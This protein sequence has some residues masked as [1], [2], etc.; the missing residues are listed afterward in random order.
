MNFGSSRAQRSGN[1]ANERC[2]LIA[3]PLLPRVADAGIFPYQRHKIAAERLARRFFVRVT[4]LFLAAVAET[5]VVVGESNIVEVDPVDAVVKSNLSERRSLKLAV[6]DPTDRATVFPRPRRFV[7]DASSSSSDQEIP[8]T[9]RRVKT[10]H[11]RVNLDSVLLPA[12]TA[13]SI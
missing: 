3:T 7:A 13:C 1:L 6:L 2:N 4:E 5:R 12:A 8:S 9:N 10:Y 11:P